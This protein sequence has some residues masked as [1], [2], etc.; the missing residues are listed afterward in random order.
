MFHNIVV[1]IDGSEIS[2]QI[3][4]TAFHLAKEQQSELSIIYVGKETTAA[5]V[6][7]IGMAYVPEDYFTSIKENVRQEGEHILQKAA[8]LAEE[9][10]I[11]GVQTFYMTGDP[12]G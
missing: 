3:L 6:A 2:H 11:I 10:G 1:A 12:A 7:F 9:A 8:S 4:E 5:S